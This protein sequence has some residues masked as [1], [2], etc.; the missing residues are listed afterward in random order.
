MNLWS[1]ALCLLWI[2]FPNGCFGL[3]QKLVVFI[4]WG[5][6]VMFEFWFGGFEDHG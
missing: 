6:V 2:G 5:D 3:A 4:R 1:Y